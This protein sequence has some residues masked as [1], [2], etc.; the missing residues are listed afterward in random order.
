VKELRTPERQIRPAAKVSIDQPHVRYWQVLTAM[1]LMAME[2]AWVVPWYRLMTWTS[3]PTTRVQAFA[4]LG[5]MLTLAYS[6]MRLMDYFQLKRKYM[7]ATM[8][9]GLIVAVV[10]GF[11]LLIFLH[12][13]VSLRYILGHIALGGFESAHFIPPEYVAILAI[14]MIWQ[15]GVSLARERLGSLN[16]ARGFKRGLI[17]IA[18]NGLVAYP[19]IGVIPTVDLYGFLFFGLVAMGA[20][21]LSTLSRLR[22]GKESPFDRRW[23]V[24]V[25]GFAAAVLVIGAIF[26]LLARG[27][28]TTGVTYL[29]TIAVN[30][31]SR[32]LVIVLWPVV[33]AGIHGLS[34]IADWIN[35]QRM[36]GQESAQSIQT[37]NELTEWL[38]QMQQGD[39][40]I[41]IE[42]IVPIL[43][44]VLLWGLACL[45]VA[46]LLLRLQR[47]LRENG[48]GG[49][50]S[51]GHSLLAEG[52]LLGLLRKAFRRRTDSL[53]QSLEK[54]RN[55]ERRLAAARIRRIYA[56]LMQLAEEL[57]CIRPESQ[58]P[59]EFL[60]L[61]NQVF[62]NLG[63][64]LVVI[65]HAY[66]R[67]RYGELPETPQELEVVEDAWRQLQ[68]AGEEKKRDQKGL[69]LGVGI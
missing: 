52:G 50:L 49:D 55:P 59:L 62:P 9:V 44:A 47:L 13:R 35:L 12:E 40:P 37:Q 45:I 5:V 32:V 18:A 54:W 39:P 16:V 23:V 46:F 3:A 14:L 33:F 69:T 20:A 31:I 19:L 36:D 53:L 34:R 60:T 66:V 29:I 6:S 27:P 17:L 30:L 1:A 11:K 24:G 65:T 63:R 41:W 22:G 21:R 67:V 4:A 51:E 38:Q 10:V 26:T 42:Q 58:T 8:V 15:R 2:L 61:L 56:D 28:L 68:V 43:K 57:G 25:L 48:Q 64:E 7:I